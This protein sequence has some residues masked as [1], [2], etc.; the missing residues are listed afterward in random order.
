MAVAVVV[1]LARLADGVAPVRALGGGDVLTRLG[2]D[3][4]AG[5]RVV[6]EA[7]AAVRGRRRERPAAAAAAAALAA[8]ALAADADPA[9]ATPPSRPTHHRP[10]RCL[11]LPR[12]RRSRTK[13]RALCRRHNRRWQPGCT[14]GRRAGW[15]RA[16][17]RLVGRT[18]RCLGCR[19]VT[20]RRSSPGPCREPR[21]PSA[22]RA[23]CL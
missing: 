19:R 11:H 10:T 21:R 9:A 7:V 20:T 16:L 4:R 1:A 12:I 22:S 6:A 14:D 23:S 17:P 2:V 8:A 5:V 18:P 15:P 3:Q 13:W